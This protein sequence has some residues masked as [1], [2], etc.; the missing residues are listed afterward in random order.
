VAPVLTLPFAV[1]LPL[2]AG[3]FIDG[4]AH[5]QADAYRLVFAGAGVLLAVSL[6]SIVKADFD[7]Q[8]PPAE[9]VV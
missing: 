3:Y 1:L 5:L 2:A 8:R 4:F 6:A 9:L 7:N